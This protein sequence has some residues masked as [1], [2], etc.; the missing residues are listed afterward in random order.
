MGHFL[1]G[2]DPKG[3]DSRLIQEGRLTLFEVSNGVVEMRT[4][5]TLAGSLLGV[6]S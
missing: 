2:V 6:L 5:E 4:D 3:S 1:N